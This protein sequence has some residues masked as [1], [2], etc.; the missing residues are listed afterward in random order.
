VTVSASYY[1]YFLFI[2]C[3]GGGEIRDSI[4]I[5][6]ITS[7]ESVER[8]YMY[9]T[10]THTHTVCVVRGWVSVVCVCVCDCVYVCV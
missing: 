9:Y 4:R 6:D 1:Y 7:C 2:Y 10:P 8:G 3:Q 5:L